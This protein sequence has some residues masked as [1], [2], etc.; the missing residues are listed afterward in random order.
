MVVKTKKN[1]KERSKRFFKDLP[2][3]FRSS[4][5]K[6]CAF[7]VRAFPW[8]LTLLWLVVIV[9]ILPLPSQLYMKH[10]SYEIF[11]ERN[12]QSINTIYN[13]DNFEDV[14]N[15]DL[16]F[17]LGI[18]YSET[19]YDKDHLGETNVTYTSADGTKYE[20]KIIV[21]MSLADQAEAVYYD[22]N[23]SFDPIDVDDVERT[24]IVFY[25]EKMLVRNNHYNNYFEYPVFNKKSFEFSNLTSP[26]ELGNYLV[27]IM[28]I[29]Y[30]S[31][32]SWNALFGAI[33]YPLILGFIIFEVV[34][35]KDVM[36][37]YSHFINVAASSS[38][39]PFILTIILSLCFKRISWFYLYDV[40]F[41]ISFITMIIIL[42]KNNEKI[43][44]EL[45]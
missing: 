8:Y 31:R 45:E 10:N 32:Y 22:Y 2:I 12:L 5:D 19:L 38:T 4:V 21:D 28:S 20:T 13:M 29:D 25:N 36:F 9:F 35:Y 33:I 23:E 7:I 40:F 37:K 18:M 27:D 24:L 16:N 17:Y 41:T 15:L 30:I 3:F 43:M 26:E 34:K 44:S 14:K 11:K 6:R 42:H 39:I 1:H